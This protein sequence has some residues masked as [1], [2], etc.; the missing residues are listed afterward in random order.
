MKKVDLKIEIWIC[1]KTYKAEKMNNLIS[2]K[3][4][5]AIT[6]LKGLKGCDKVNKGELIK[7]LDAILPNGF[8]LA[9]LSKKELWVIARERG[10]EN[11]KKMGRTEL[12]KTFS[13]GLA[14]WLR[15]SVKTLRAIVKEQDFEG[16]ERMSKA[17]LIEVLENKGINLQRLSLETLRVFAREGHLIEGCDTMSKD[18]IIETFSSDGIEL[19]LSEGTLRKILKTAGIKGCNRMIFPELI[20][21]ILSN[22]EILNRLELNL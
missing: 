7:L 5:K 2:Q 22:R 16:C 18:E 20:D 15:L 8:N 1:R 13:P 6:K 9:D 19:E 17:E 4:L 10:V 3:E 14:E 12:I 11:Y 21:A